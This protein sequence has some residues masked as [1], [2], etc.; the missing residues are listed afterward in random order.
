MQQTEAYGSKNPAKPKLDNQQEIIRPII[1]KLIKSKTKGKKPSEIDTTASW[2]GKS[3]WMTMNSLSKPL[4]QR[5]VSHFSNCENKKVELPT[6]NVLPG[7][8]ILQK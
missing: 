5:K 2:E 1:V 3:V 6:K 4:G 7:E 8:H